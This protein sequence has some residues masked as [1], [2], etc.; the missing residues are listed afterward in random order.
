MLVEVAT[1]FYVVFVLLFF[2]FFLMIRRPP[3]S[4]LFPYTTLFRSAVHRAKLGPDLRDGVRPTRI[5]VVLGDR[6]DAVR[7]TGVD[8][9]DD[10][11]LSVVSGGLAGDAV[12]RVGQDRLAGHVP[13]AG[14]GH[15]I[16]GANARV[17]SLR[18]A[19]RGADEGE[20]RHIEARVPIRAVVR[21][22]RRYIQ[23]EDDVRQDPPHGGD[24]APHD[25]PR[26]LRRQ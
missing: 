26:F 16:G 2:L 6:D 10:V 25:L 11:P 9:A 12:A 21:D 19:A 15:R 5:R 20:V 24:D 4:T 23:R 13:Y 18:A 1:L 8:I 17:V 7:D 14:P 22:P 3:R